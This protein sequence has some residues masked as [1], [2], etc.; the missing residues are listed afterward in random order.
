VDVVILVLHNQQGGGKFDFLFDPVLIGRGDE[1]L[2][3]QVPGE[4]QELVPAS[5]IDSVEGFV[6][7]QYMDLGLV[8]VEKETGDG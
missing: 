2:E 1:K 5:G 8:A 3:A 4:S 6:E 7:K